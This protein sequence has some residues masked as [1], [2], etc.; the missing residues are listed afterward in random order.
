MQTY[1]KAPLFF[2]LTVAF[3]AVMPQSVLATE[4]RSATHFGVAIE[5]R[6]STGFARTV[7]SVVFLDA[8][9]RLWSKVDL[10]WRTV[11]FGGESEDGQ[12]YRLGVGPL[13]TGMITE[14]WSI[15]ACPFMFQESARRADGEPGYTSRGS[16]VMLGW[17]RHWALGERTDISW[18][19]FIARHWGS[20]APAPSTSPQTTNTAQ[21]QWSDVS[22]NDGGSRGVELALRVRL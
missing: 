15:E 22:R 5:D 3:T 9:F 10:G 4:I 11:G 6:S 1:F 2:A 8:S 13:V 17:H 7:G 21:T 20:L 12:F 14:K 18:G 19:G 16:S